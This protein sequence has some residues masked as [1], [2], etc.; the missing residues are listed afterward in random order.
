MAITVQ[1]LVFCIVTSCSHAGGPTF[2]KNM[3]LTGHHPWNHQYNPITITEHKDR[4]FLQITS[5]NPQEY[6]LSKPRRTQSK[7]VQYFI[8]KSTQVFTMLYSVTLCW[9]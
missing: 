9:K 6:I 2:Q 3:L 8:T 4:M 5:I 1:F 7:L